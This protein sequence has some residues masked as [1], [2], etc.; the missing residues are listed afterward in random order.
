MRVERRKTLPEK[1]MKTGYPG[2][3]KSGPGEI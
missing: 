1:K 2:E 3:L